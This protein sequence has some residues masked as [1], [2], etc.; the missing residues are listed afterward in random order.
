MSTLAEPR[1]EARMENHRD[2]QIA[3]RAVDYVVFGV[4]SPERAVSFYRDTLGLVPLG[5][6]SGGP[7]Q[8]FQVGATTLAI[9]APPLGEPPQAGYKGGATVALAV[10]DVAAAVAALRGR[11][12]P[13][14]MDT[15]ETPVCHY[16]LIADPDGNRLILHRRKDGSAG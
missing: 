11:G 6:A 4:S 14:L 2:G 1:T 13:V 12:V 3:P 15:V 10:E 7:W 16:A 5:E 9:S 8:E